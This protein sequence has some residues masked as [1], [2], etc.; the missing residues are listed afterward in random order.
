[1]LATI[2]QV[3]LQQEQTTEK[4]IASLKTKAIKYSKL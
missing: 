4:C 2:K 3:A 1:M